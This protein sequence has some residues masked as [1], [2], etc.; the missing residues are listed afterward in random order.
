MALYEHLTNALR[1]KNSCKD[2]SAKSQTI[3]LNSRGHACRQEKWKCRFSYIHTPSRY[4]RRQ[5]GDRVNS[6]SSVSLSYGV[7]ERE[8]QKKTKK[9]IYIERI[10]VSNKYID[11]FMRCGGL[12]VF[13]S[14]IRPSG[15]CTRARAFYNVQ[16]ICTYIFTVHCC[17]CVYCVIF[18]LSRVRYIVIGPKLGIHSS[19]ACI[20]NSHRNR[21]RSYRLS[22]RVTPNP[23]VE[24]ST[25]D[26]YEHSRFKKLAGYIC[27]LYNRYI[28]IHISY[29]IQSFVVHARA[30]DRRGKSVHTYYMKRFGVILGD[31][32]RAQ[33]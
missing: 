33:V 17:C 18:V 6:R 27:I 29:N 13:H 12:I 26:I 28:G 25:V 31:R 14:T 5:M 19:F 11:K 3:Q 21:T 32:C 20:E 4:T 2:E 15:A 24:I 22:I 7:K 9:K 30:R 8:K 10:S 23:H 16:Y 1:K